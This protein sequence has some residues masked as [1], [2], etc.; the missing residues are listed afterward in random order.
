MLKN[1]VLPVL[2]GLILF[3]V[4]DRWK[5]MPTATYAVS[6]AI[7]IPNPE[8]N[9]E[10]AQEVSIFNSGRNLVKTISIKVPRH[11]STYRLTKHSNQIHEKSFS[12][13]NSFELVYP[14]L[15]QGQRI[16]L[17]VRYEGTPIERD[18][19]SI[20]H[21]D[22]N[23]QPQDN[24]S[25]S[26]S[27]FWIWIAFS[28]GFLSN[29]VLDLRKFR[30]EW[31]LKWVDQKKLLQN[32]RPWFCTSSE[33]RELQFEAIDRALERYS[34]E[35]IEQKLS[36]ILLSRA[37]PSLLPEEQW[38]KLQAHATKLLEQSFSSELTAYSRKDKLL[39][40]IKIKK[41]EGLPLHN[42]SI[43]QDSLSARLHNILLPEYTKASDLIDI[44]EENSVVL[45]DVPAP[46]ATKIREAAQTRYFK[47]LQEQ[48]FETYKNAIE[49]IDSARLDLLTSNQSERLREFALKLTKLRAVP[50]RWSI[51]GLESFV[52]NG[53]P[54]WMPEEEFNDIRDL[55]LE[56]NN[57]SGERSTLQ[58]KL[59]TLVTAQAEVENLKSRVI[60][61]L[62]LVDKVLSDPSSIDKL[63]GY[64]PTFAPGNRKNLELV[65]SILKSVSSSS[66]GE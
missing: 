50:S 39:D 2:V 42:W 44:L 55:V 4:Q 33:W 3:L 5:D 30:K 8:G 13:S 9:L 12:E 34:Y 14:E 27:Y 49:T 36:Y 17:L 6:E 18:W 37:K 54:Q 38:S 21:A 28:I 47:Y 45:R 1:L 59:S 58:T 19:I 32:E 43:I 60:A 52:D 15:P 56:A 23:A 35:P 63:E 65:A 22:G 62:N 24:Q 25:P 29:I 66:A 26:I 31:F 64:D 48:C 46:L 53:K 10:Y 51:H 57:L 20:S 11:I 16:R 41:P 61:Q 40:L 7:Q